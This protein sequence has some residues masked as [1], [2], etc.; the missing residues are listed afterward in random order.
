MA[1]NPPIYRFASGV[2]TE[3]PIGVVCQNARFVFDRAV[4]LRKNDV[5]TLVDGQWFVI[6]DGDA[7]LIEGKWD[8]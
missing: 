4:H 2:G 7:T 3:I 6:R 5:L 8:R 1:T